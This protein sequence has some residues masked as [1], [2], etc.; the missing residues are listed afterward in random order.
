M[1]IELKFVLVGFIAWLV[2]LFTGAMAENGRH[3]REE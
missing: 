2:G 3:D 1:P